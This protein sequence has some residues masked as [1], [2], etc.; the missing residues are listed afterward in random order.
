MIV[1]DYR[2]S[3][4]IGRDARIPTVDGT[5]RRYVNLDYAATTPALESVQAAVEEFLPFY[6]SAHRGAGYKSR[7]ATAALEG[8][9]AA[10]ADFVGCPR[11][12]HVI[13]VRNTTEA[14]NLLSA[15]LPAEPG[16]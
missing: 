14:I 12:G 2:L 10:V 7:L 5:E 4:V 16:L 13:F 11:D 6:S 8:A 15:A 9:R 1:S 3:S